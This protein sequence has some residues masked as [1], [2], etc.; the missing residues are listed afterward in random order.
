MISV[1]VLIPDACEE[2]KMSGVDTGKGIRGEIGRLAITTAPL[3]EGRVH[4]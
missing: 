3:V 2:G 4:L 1:G